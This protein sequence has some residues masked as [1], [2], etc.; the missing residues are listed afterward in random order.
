MHHEPPPWRKWIEP[1]V[2]T[3]WA[4]ILI[5]GITWLLQLQ[6]KSERCI[7]INAGQEA[8]INQLRIDRT[9]ARE[10]LIGLERDM[11][12]MAAGIDEIKALIK[13]QQR[14]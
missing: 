9:D 7:E 12:N 4:L 13:Q 3:R 2:V 6:F 10:R 5:G 8:A 14:Q 1:A 11:K